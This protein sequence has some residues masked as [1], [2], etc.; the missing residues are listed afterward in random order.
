M[1]EKNVEGLMGDI[2]NQIHNRDE[3]INKMLSYSEEIRNHFTIIEPF[4]EEL[5]RNMG[6]DIG[7]Q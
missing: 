2:G 4:Y 5:A 3:L 6:M 1:C 7:K